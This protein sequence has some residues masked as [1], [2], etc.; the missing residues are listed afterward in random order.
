M[1]SRGFIAGLLWGLVVATSGLGVLSLVAKSPETIVAVGPDANAAADG[2]EGGTEAGVPLADG[3][4]DPPKAE[5]TAGAEATVSLS[6]GAGSSVA[7]VAAGMAAGDTAAG[8]A[9]A[10]TAAN[11]A[12]PAAAE[13]AA[14]EPAATEPAAAEPATAEPAAEPAAAEPAIKEPATAEP[15]EA[16]VVNDA[17]GQTPLAPPS[18]PEQVVTPGAEPAPSLPAGQELPAVA[19][20]DAAP[21]R[22]DTGM[23]APAEDALLNPTTEAGTEDAV[24][25]A[26]EADAEVAPAVD[27]GAEVAP[28]A[29]AGGAVAP[30]A[31]AGV[32]VAPAADAG[33]EVAPAAEAGT[34]VAPAAD[35]G[36]ADAPAAD[37]GAEA[38][39]AEGGGST[40]DAA[41]GLSKDADGV[42]TGRLPSIGDDRASEAARTAPESEPAPALDLSDAPPILAYARAFTAEAGKPLFSIVLQDLGDK[43]MPRA[44]LAK[45]PFAVTFVVDP[46]APDA[47]EAVATYRAAGQEVLIL[48]NVP[49]GAT[50]GDLEQGF[51]A[52]AAGLPET[53]GYLDPAQDGLK[54]NRALATQAVPILKEQGR[55]I[56]AFGGGLDAVGQVARREGLAYAE[57]YRSMDAE[58][59]DTPLVRR[60]LDRAAFKAAQEGQVV[61]FGHTRPETVAALLEWMV[62]G[63]ASMVQVAPVTALMGLQAQ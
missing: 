39:L 13:P 37:A 21:E 10:A 54:E 11:E 7:E 40:L 43:G 53:V 62:E 17:S 34:E 58:G 1:V 31:E 23:P 49:A 48:A 35:V 27:A 19:G 42:V 61:V 51:Q 20:P 24:A 63:R 26:A 28:A 15:A 14:A 30:A 36:V 8:V 16:P 32:A 6:S 41:P 52:M 3:A 25:P 2:A 57:I 55:G 50:A 18:G 44:E 59:E 29:E 38:A 60:Y 9:A 56:V 22:A 5:V 33:A 45:L 46:A 12:E 4:G 47:A